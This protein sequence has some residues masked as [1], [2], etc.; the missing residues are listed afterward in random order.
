MIGGLFDIFANEEDKKETIE[1]GQTVENAKLILGEEELNIAK[2]K[3]QTGEVILGKEIIGE[4]KTVNVP[5]THEEALLKEDLSMNT[6]IH[7]LA[8]K[9]L[10]RSKKPSEKK[11]PEWKQRAIPI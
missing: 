11:K 1:N 5:V 4:Q 7:L 8:L 2:N 3:V 9:K 6:V 10:D